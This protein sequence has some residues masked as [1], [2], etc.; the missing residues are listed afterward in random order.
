MGSVF[1]LLEAHLSWLRSQIPPMK[2][3]R[4]F[5][6]MLVSDVSV[7]GIRLPIYCVAFPTCR[8]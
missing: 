4:P 6:I 2:P 3:W 5:A 8:S 1:P 7:E